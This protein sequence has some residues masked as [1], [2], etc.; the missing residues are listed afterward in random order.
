MKKRI[1]SVVVILALLS[2]VASATVLRDL[3]WTYFATSSASIYKSGDAIEWSG[4]ASTYSTPTVTLTKVVVKLQVATDVGWGTI[5]TLTGTDKNDAIA[6]STY[7]DWKAG[8]SYRSSVEAWAYNGSKELEH[9]GPF[10]E[11]LY[12]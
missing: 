5:E 9:I 3:R 12:T 2:G 10:Y 1:I 8:K 7:T 11:Y 6:G 4:D